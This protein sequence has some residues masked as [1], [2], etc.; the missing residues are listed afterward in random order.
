MSDAWFFDSEPEREGRSWLSVLVI[1]LIITNI[2]IVSYFTFWYEPDI[3]SDMMQRLEGTVE[4]LQFR[5]SSLESEIDTLE[6]ELRIFN[7]F[8]TSQRSTIPLI[9]NSTKRSVVLIQV[10]TATGGG[11]G[12][13][14][15]YDKDGHIIT[16]NH[17]VE[18]AQSITITFTDGTIA[19]ASINDI[20]RDPY[21]D[22]AVIKVDVSEDRLEPVTLGN[23]SQLV[24][25]EYVVAIGAPFG[26]DTTMTAGIISATGR[27]MDAPGGYAI[28]DVI[29]T[30]AAINPGNSGGPLLDL[31]G[32][33]IG[34]NTAIIGEVRQ[35][36]GIGF[37]IPSDT[38][39]REVPSLISIGDYEHPWLGITGQTMTPEIAR[40]MDLNDDTRG[41]LVVEVVDSGP[42]DKAGL[43][44]GDR[45]VIIDGIRT[46]V[47]GDIIIGV[48][49]TTINS[50]YDLV[51]YIERYK[52]PGD[53]ITMTIIRENRMMELELILGARPPP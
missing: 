34:M 50:F 29:Q 42:A 27:Q 7:Q 53:A 15:I 6:T 40:E 36:S 24:V 21:S 48:D 35:F 17:V 9:Y 43:R 2:G 26:L 18:G 5:I 32:N 19:E 25:G 49:E 44:G 12:S 30:D 14:F 33:V 51:F 22:L 1:F 38:I 4:S 41:V 37:A 46:T 16:N 47:G 10:Q 39:K 52:R 11:Q 8:N 3:D 20:G 13:G 45:V 31:E 28:V 23:S